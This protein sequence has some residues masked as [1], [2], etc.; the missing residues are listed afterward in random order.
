MLAA[1]SI[2]QGRVLRTTS[3]II[4][5][6]GLGL[7]ALLMVMLRRRHSLTVRAAVLVGTAIAVELA[8]TLLQAKFAI[9]VDTALWHVAIA[10]YLAA[11][12]LDEIDFRKLLGGVA[13]RRFQRIAMSLGDG[14]VCTDQ[15]G[16]IT[17]WNPGAQAIFGFSPEEMIGRQLGSI[18]AVG[19][20][21][22]LDS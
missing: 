22:V 3:K 6:V 15:N 17:V 20:R 21:A 12:A 2:M 14:L 5:I 11:T 8:A 16:L 19:Q 18:A 10:T 13:E 9:I 7:I 4:T 1:E